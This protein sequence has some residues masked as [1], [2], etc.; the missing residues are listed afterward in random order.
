MSCLSTIREATTE[1]L[2]EICE[3]V[4]HDDIE[5]ANPGHHHVLVLDTETDG[6]CAVALVTIDGDRGHLTELAIADHCIGQGIE[7]RLIG[8]VEALCTAFGASTLDVPHAA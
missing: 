7:D 8:V 5:L 2:P 3:L 1:D 4:G 6:I